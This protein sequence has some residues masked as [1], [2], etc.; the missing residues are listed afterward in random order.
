MAIILKYKESLIISPEE[1]FWVYDLCEGFPTWDETK[2]EYVF[3]RSPK[4]ISA[5][6]AKEI[7]KLEGLHCVANNE[8]GRIYA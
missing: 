7:I 8:H 4:R 5:K 2:Q 3:K 6:K 1:A